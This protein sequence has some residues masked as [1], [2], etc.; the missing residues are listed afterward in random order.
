MSYLD[1]GACVRVVLGDPWALRPNQYAFEEHHDKFSTHVQELRDAPQVPFVHG[2]T[3]PTVAK[4]AWFSDPRHLDS[5]PNIVRK[6]NLERNTTKIQFFVQMIQHTFE[7]GTRNSPKTH[8]S[9]SLDRKV[10]P[11]PVLPD[12]PGSSQGPLKMPERKHKACQMA[13]LGAKIAISVPQTA[14]NHKSWSNEH[15]PSAGGGG[16]SR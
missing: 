7:M 10:S 14:E 6:R 12:A 11:P 9:W 1:Y 15:W 13:C 16:R 5:D 4:D 3:M 2:F 8:K